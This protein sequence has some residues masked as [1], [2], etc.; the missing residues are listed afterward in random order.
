MKQHKLYQEVTCEVCGRQAKSFLKS[1]NICSRCHRK[2][3]S[4]PCQNCGYMTHNITSETILCLRC[5]KTLSKPLA[6]C[7][8]C[9]KTKIIHDTHRWLCEPCCKAVDRRD[10]E[11]LKQIQVI[12]SVC[13]KTVHSVLTSR[14]ICH[15][16]FIKERNG[17]DFCSKCSQYKVIYK[18]DKH[19]AEYL[20]KR[21]D[22]EIAASRLLEDYVKH[23]QTPY[24]YNKRLFDLLVKTIDWDKV[25]ERY[26]QSIRLL[27]KLLQTHPLPEPLTWEAIEEFMPD[28]NST[29]S[30][31]RSKL[32]RSRLLDLGHILVAKGQLE[33]FESYCKNK[34]ILRSLENIPQEIQSLLRSFII[35][36]Q[37]RKNRPSSIHH[38]VRNLG[39]FW[40]WCFQH[41][42]TSLSLIQPCHIKE[43]LKSLYW[44]WQCSQCQTSF[45]SNIYEKLADKKCNYCGIH[46][47][48]FQVPRFDNDAL[49]HIKG[50]LRIFFDWAKIH[51]LVISNPVQGTIKAPAPKISHYPFEVIQKLSNF[52]I[53][54]QSDPTEALILYLIIFHALTNWELRHAK[55]TDLIYLNKDIYR[56]SLAETYYI[57][58]PK[59]PV[60]KGKVSSGRVSEQLKFS[61]AASQWLKPLL[62]RFEAQRLQQLKNLNNQ[63][64]IIAPNHKSRHLKPVSTRFIYNVVKKVCLRTIN[65]QCN[66]K[67]LRIT[68][69]V[70]FADRAGG[71]ILEWMGWGEQQA[72]FY[73]W[74]DREV[75]NPMQSYS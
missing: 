52:I 72:F 68:A 43:Y 22:A 41:Q 6:I 13:S 17:Y 11:K 38:Y 60:S 4:L 32:L 45:S 10:H 58:V 40:T 35:W 46:G 24:L 65:A 69:A 27:G 26:K 61:S 75:I 28:L 9:N 34:S 39:D 64:L 55:I 42:L 7:S 37:K 62:E 47:N 49:R 71:G 67:T 51:K 3:H 73:S 36:L 29:Q 12:C 16:C 15:S 25:T 56:L 20:C 19:K 44:Q 50:Q 33:D 1:R 23:F 5:T 21:C 2:E 30:R 14:P 54:P 74:G 31:H 66:I 53:N 8:R 18:I 59:P 63:F 57:V 70:M 48:L